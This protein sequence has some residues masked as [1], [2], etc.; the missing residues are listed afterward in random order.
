MG[1]GIVILEPELDWRHTRNKKA[2]SSDPLA[3]HII[4]F[5]AKGKNITQ[6][7]S[8]MNSEAKSA[9]RHE[10]LLKR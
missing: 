4:I 1:G 9:A 3:R 6:C 10:H 5:Q 7:F 2:A 8:D